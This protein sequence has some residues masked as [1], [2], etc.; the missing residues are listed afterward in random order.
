MVRAWSPMLGNA[1]RNFPG[2]YRADDDRTTELA[3]AIERNW[4]NRSQ[5]SYAR[6]PR[7]DA[8]IWSGVR[9]ETHGRVS[10]ALRHSS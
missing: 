4:H 5:G 1:G 8:G 9:L 3:H 10:A 7:L 2:T 6:N